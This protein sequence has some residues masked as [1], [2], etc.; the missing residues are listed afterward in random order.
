MTDRDGNGRLDHGELARFVAE[1]P[2][3]L[4]AEDRKY[5]VGLQKV[6]EVWEGCGN[7]WGLRGTCGTLQFSNTGRM[8]VPEW[9]QW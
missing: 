1:I 3:Q 5:L 4:T 9:P 6:W 2:G 7:V 8:L